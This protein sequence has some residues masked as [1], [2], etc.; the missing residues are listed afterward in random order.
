MAQKFSKLYD[1]AATNL[2]ISN[3]AFVDPVLTPVKQYRNEDVL[4]IGL[5]SNLNENKG[6]S[7]FIQSIKE[8][9]RQGVNIQGVLAG[10]TSTPQDAKTI[11]TAQKD[12]GEALDYRGALYGK[13]KAQFY[14]DIDIFIFPTRN[15]AQPT[16]IVEAMAQGIPILSRDLGCIKS[17]VGPCGAVFKMDK[18][19]PSAAIEWVTD[20]IN[21]LNDLKKQARKSF[22]ADREKAIH[23]AQNLLT[24][25]A[26]SC[27][28]CEYD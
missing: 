12:L 13:D 2:V 6:L 18:D 9:R 24:S 11:E 15:E 1:K 8:L 5:I 20:N 23:I 19:F 26:S 28:N 10:P 22:L 3:S 4:K 14:A 17:Q 27:E 25:V 21:I 7:D 16:V